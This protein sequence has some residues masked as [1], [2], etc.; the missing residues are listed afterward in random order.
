[1][2]S[3]TDPLRNGFRVILSDSFLNTHIVPQNLPTIYV[4]AIPLR[5]P[6][7]V[8]ETRYTQ[9]LY[10][11]SVAADKQIT[12]TGRYLDLIRSLSITPSGL[13][14]RSWYYVCI[15]WES[16]NRYNETTGRP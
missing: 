12:I 11:E 13:R 9:I 1:M 14:E 7:D 8:S 6:S 2:N 15:E 10:P 4:T 3:L 5:Q 16:L